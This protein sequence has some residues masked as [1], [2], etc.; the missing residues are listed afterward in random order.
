MKFK[1]RIAKSIVDNKKITKNA[2]FESETEE[3]SYADHLYDL[4]YSGE[5]DSYDNDDSKH[6]ES[7][8][9]EAISTKRNKKYAGNEE[10]DDYE[11]NDEWNNSKI[12]DEAREELEEK[13]NDIILKA[14]DESKS[15]GDLPKDI[16]DVLNKF[17]D[18]NENY[19]NI[20]ESSS[21]RNKRYANENQ[22]Q[23]GQPVT[24]PDGAQGTVK[25]TYPDANGSGTVDV[26]ANGATETYG[27]DEV[28]TATKKRGFRR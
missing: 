7:S 26:D 8:H 13:W 2:S 9:K 1:D 22:P 25:A 10:L 27:F 21:R 18:D 11:N 28:K 16:K 19:D 24:L 20:K 14:L 3:M 4:Y 12:S 15:F 17:G 23:V 6:S 5:H